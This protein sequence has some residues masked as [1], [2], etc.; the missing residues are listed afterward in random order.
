HRPGEFDGTGY[1]IQLLN[2]NAS[3]LTLSSALVDALPGNVFV[4]AI[5]NVVKTCTG[6]VTAVAG[7]TSITY[8]NGASIPAG[9]CSIS[10]DVTATDQDGNPLTLWAENGY[11]YYPLPSFATFVDHGDGTGT[12]TFDPAQAGPG[13]HPIMLLARDDGDGQGERR[14]LTGDYTFIVSIHRDNFA[15]TLRGEANRVAVVGRTLEVPILA[16]DYEQGELQFELQ[17]L[18][19]G[20]TLVD[21][22]VYGRKL[23]RWTPTAADVGT[24]TASVT[25][26]D[27]GAGWLHLVRDAHTAFAIT[28][29]AAN[30]TPTLPLLDNQTVAEGQTLQ[31][32][33]AALAADPDGH[34]L[35][36]EIDAGSLPDGAALDRGTGQF[37]WT[38]RYDQA[39]TYPEIVVRVSDGDAEVVRK[40]S[41]TVTDVNRPPR[42]VPIPL[43]FGREGYLVEFAVQGGDP[44]D[45]DQLTWSVLNTDLPPESYYL[46]VSKGLFR[47]TPDYDQQGMHT[48]TFQV[49]DASGATDTLDVLLFIDDVNRAPIVKNSNHQVKLGQTL[50]FTIQAADPDEAAIL[51]YS[52]TGLP[53]GATVDRDTGRFEWTPTAGQLGEHVVRL[54]VADGTDVTSESIVL[55]ATLSPILPGITVVRSPSWAVDP[56]TPVKLQVLTNGYADIAPDSVHVYVDGVEYALDED[57]FATVTASSIPGKMVITAVATDADGWQ[58]T[59]QGVIEVLNPYDNRAPEL[60]LQ[61]QAAQGPL[62]VPTQVW[63]SVGDSNLDS[64]TLA[65]ARLGSESF[66]TLAAGDSPVDS[67][68]L[69]TLDPAAFPAGFYRLRLSAEDIGNRTNAVETIIE[70]A[71]ADTSDVYRQVATDLT[72]ELWGGTAYSL[73]VPINRYYDSAAKDIPGSAGYGW[74]LSIRDVNLQLNVPETGRERYG[75]YSSLRDRS[76]LYLTTPAGDRIKF[77]FA[78]Q[79]VFEAPAVTYYRPAWQ[80]ADPNVD[81][82]LDSVDALLLRS[83]NSFYLVESGVPYHPANPQLEGSDYV[84]TGADGTQ[85][86]IDSALGIVRQVTPGGAAV[87]VS[88]SGLIADDGSYVD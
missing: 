38:P 82:T 48:I 59:M 50:A 58:G 76:E 75:V 53:E 15:P 24:Y 36:Y 29:L 35:S 11:P 10:V 70:I 84:L 54:H 45:Y 33:F 88:T 1:T 62:R 61:Q 13:D 80:T 21:T 7:A 28:V 83:G 16:S 51:K 85:Y 40:F 73:A 57:G 81:F 79:I 47:L 78:P 41:I 22:A 77:E 86:H 49:Q 20:A 39:G 44:D 34:T 19:A 12:F 37:S 42:I 87:H 55:S 74:Q 9:G 25:V 2:G 69:A 5:P 65:I 4:A 56:N 27:D 67:Q 6:A 26:R 31:I 64:W 32:D 71:A 68:A 18:P 72:V 14:Q 43:Q 3:A 60:V 63:G 8:A 23:L 17:G 66:L 52:A 30:S 46:N